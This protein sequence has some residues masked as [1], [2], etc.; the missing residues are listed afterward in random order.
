[1]PKLPLQRLGLRLLSLSAP[2]CPSLE[3]LLSTVLLV[4]A[5]LPPAPAPPSAHAVLLRGSLCPNRRKKGDSVSFST[6]VVFINEEGE[7]HTWHS[8]TGAIP[9][10]DVRETVELP[11]PETKQ[12]N[13]FEVTNRVFAYKGSNCTVRVNVRLT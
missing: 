8:E 9:V 10:P 6:T 12:L 5:S 2:A 3:V 4:L 11:D 13:P 7:E 1:V